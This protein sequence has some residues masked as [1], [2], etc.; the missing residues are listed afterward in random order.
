MPRARRT[1]VVD[2]EA[3]LRL[4]LRLVLE[5][6]GRY[7][8]VGEAG[9]GRA[10]LELAEEHRPEVVLLDLSMP[11]MDGLEVLPRLRR[12][13]PHAHLVVLSGYAASGAAEPATRAG[14]DAYLEKGLTPSAMLRAIDATAV[15]GS[16]AA[17]PRVR[18]RARPDP[19]PPSTDE[20]VARLAHDVRTPLTTAAGALDVLRQTLPPEVDPDVRDLIRRAVAS[21]E[22]VDATLGATIEH[23]RTGSAR[24][25]PSEFEVG[26]VVDALL[27]TIPDAL[28]RVRVEGDPT[29]RAFAD[30]PALQRVL[31]NLLENALRYSDGTVH[32]DLR[33]D[34]SAAHIDVRDHGP[35][36]GPQADAYFEPFVRGDGASGHHGS[37]LGLATAADLVRR[38]RGELSAHDAPDGGAVFTVTL[39]AG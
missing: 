12:L 33:L 3:D 28:D 21:L 14:A 23:A 22:R 32:V 36:L 27:D 4:L 5:R 25:E 13:L 6:S 15:P 30:R 18:R 17:L 38:M 1:L 34:G 39:P 7:E 16:E 20:V 10:A 24:L 29:L 26:P 2:D 35:G 9:D 19:R 37:G 8:V 31:G 11:R